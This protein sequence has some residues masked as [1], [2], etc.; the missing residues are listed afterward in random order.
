MARTEPASRPHVLLQQLAH[1]GEG[2]AERLG[3][4]D[5]L[6]APQ[7]VRPVLAVAARRPGR[8]G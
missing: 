5:E 3:S 8:L 2:E 7:V 1:L 6:E 4:S